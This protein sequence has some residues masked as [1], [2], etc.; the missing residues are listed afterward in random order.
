M[1]AV[2]TTHTSALATMQSRAQAR[3]MREAAEHLVENYAGEFTAGEVLT[4]VSEAKARMRA[5]YASRG[6]EAP[7]PDEFVALI[8]L[9]AQHDLDAR[10]DQS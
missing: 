4:A 5:L 8:H 1:S 10:H 9:L 2:A 7:P 6:I 3:S